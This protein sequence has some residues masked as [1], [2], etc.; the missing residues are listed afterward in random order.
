[1]F[2]TY[3]NADRAVAVLCFSICTIHCQVQL[4]CSIPLLL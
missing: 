1:M 3:N 4:H 2:S